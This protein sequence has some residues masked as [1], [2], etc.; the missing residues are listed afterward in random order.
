[1]ADV[2]ND[3]DFVSDLADGTAD[4]A[5]ATPHGAQPAHI[6]APKEVKDAAPEQAAPSLRDQISNALKSEADTP[7]AAQQDGG[8]VRGP[9]GKFISPAAQA[10]A[11]PGGAEAVASSPVAVPPGIDPQVFQSLPA[12]TQ[13]QIV[14]TMEDL[15]TRA[16]RVQQYEQLDS[17]I[18][19]RQQAWAMS[20]YTPV[21]AINQLVALGEFATADPQKFIKY[22]AEQSNIDLEDVLFGT[23]TDTPEDPTAA[24]LRREIE[25][26]RGTVNGFT[27]Q[28]QQTAHQN[29]VD[30]VIAMASEKDA[31]GNLVRPYFE[32]LGNEIL[33]YIQ[34]EMQQNPNRSQNDIINAAYDRACWATPTVRTKMQEATAMQTEAE[35]IRRAGQARNAG[36]SMSPGTPTAPPPSP[37]DGSMSLRDTIR[38]AASQ[39][40]S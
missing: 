19:P 21:Q 33:P 16:V 9:D 13:S 23:D 14:R 6:N 32:T 35:R 31:Q 24:A 34:L 11:E 40:G 28:Q 26:L 10:A 39:H 12:E 38:A 5:A 8:P 7:P 4:F 18:A 15:N 36:A 17:I 20:G 37:S 1:M 2:T 25:E 30:T 22:F 29:T 27:T 3:V